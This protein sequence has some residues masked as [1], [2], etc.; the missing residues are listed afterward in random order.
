MIEIGIPGWKALHLTDLVLDVNGTLTRD[1]QVVAGVA[2]RLAVLRQH[3]QLHLLSADTLGR[4]DAIAAELDIVGTRVQRGE[5]ESEQ[6]ARFVEELGAA[7]VVSVGNGA[8]D[9]GMLRTAGLGIAVLGAE[10]LAVGL[11][12]VADVLAASILD[13]LDMLLTPNRVVATLRR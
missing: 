8:N 6:K 2:E 10:G 13:A 11:I 7:G 12:G 9:I 1:G 5:S 3:L 4:L